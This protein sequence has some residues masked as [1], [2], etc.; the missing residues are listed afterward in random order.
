MHNR[1]TVKVQ[2]K[3]SED[4]R[5]TA[6]GVLDREGF[7]QEQ[8][9]YFATG[10]KGDWYVIGGR[11]SG[12]LTEL[13]HPTEWKRLEK[14]AQVIIDAEKLSHSVDA[15]TLSINPHIGTTELHKAL[16][17]LWISELGVPLNRDTYLPTGYADDAI[18]I[19]YKVRK[20]LLATKELELY[21][22]VDGTET[23]VRSLTKK[24]DGYWLVV[25]DYH[26]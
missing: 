1:Y 10:G 4:A 3:A 23:T 11:S 21:D 20:A 5:R 7:V 2:A 8:G 13:M 14:R 9:G 18:K 17:D 26:N 25:V 19:T 16:D 12:W 15:R 24:D 6:Y 22:D